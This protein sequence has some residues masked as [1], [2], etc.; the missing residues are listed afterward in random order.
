MKIA[1]IYCK[2]NVISF[3]YVTFWYNISI[4]QATQA[5]ERRHASTILTISTSTSSMLSPVKWYVILEHN[6]N[7]ASFVHDANLWQKLYIIV[8]YVLMQMTI[9]WQLHLKNQAANHVNVSVTMAFNNST[10]KYLA[11][12]FKILFSVLML[13]TGQTHEKWRAWYL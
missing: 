11:S 5:Y 12:V 6:V 10:T 4:K 9:L 7:S 8:H 1:Y 3:S 13:L 2:A